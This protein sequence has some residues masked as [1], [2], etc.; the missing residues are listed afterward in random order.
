MTLVDVGVTSLD[1]QQQQ[2]DS[3]LD[4]VKGNHV[5]RFRSRD[6]RLVWCIF[7]AGSL[8]LNLRFNLI[9]SLR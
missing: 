9:F 5:T 8:F 6:I 1:K 3:P 2:I 7:T 4:L